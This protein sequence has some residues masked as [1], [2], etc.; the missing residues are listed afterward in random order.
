M[1]N[2]LTLQKIN[3]IDERNCEYVYIDQLS[4]VIG[5]KSTD[6]PYNYLLSSNSD[7]FYKTSS[8]FRKVL[9]SYMNQMMKQHDYEGGWQEA[10]QTLCV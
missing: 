10:I 1:K 7:G 6:I 5:F 3:K 4:R 9:N 8:N 2:I